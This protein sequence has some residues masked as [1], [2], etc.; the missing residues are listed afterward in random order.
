MIQLDSVSAAHVRI[1]NLKKKVSRNQT[2]LSFALGY[3]FK[4]LAMI[5]AWLITIL[6]D[7][8]LEL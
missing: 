5:P 8:V 6:K 1:D 7:I 4:D 3:I 2:F